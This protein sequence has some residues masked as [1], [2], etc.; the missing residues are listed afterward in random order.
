[1]VW[2]VVFWSFAAVVSVALLWMLNQLVDPM[3]HC[4]EFDD[5][6]E[7]VDARR[8]P[9]G[10]DSIRWFNAEKLKRLDHLRNVAKWHSDQ[11]DAAAK[12]C[13]ELICLP[14]DGEYEREVAEEIA[15]SGATV[16]DSIMRIADAR[17]AVTSH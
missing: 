1:M 17:R 11:I 2:S 13:V 10:C 7:L 5:E 12:E 8:K 9:D 16:T 3:F 6:D 4:G 15:L 14:T